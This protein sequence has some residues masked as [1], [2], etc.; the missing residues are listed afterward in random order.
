MDCPS[1]YADFNLIE[2]VLDYL[3]RGFSQLGFPPGTLRKN[4]H[5]E[6][7]ALYPLTLVDAHLNCLTAHCAQVWSCLHH[8][9]DVNQALNKFK[10]YIDGTSI[11]F[12]SDPQF[13]K[14]LVKLK[15]LIRR[16]VPIGICNYNPA[17]LTWST[18]PKSLAH[19]ASQGAHLWVSTGVTIPRCP[20]DLFLFPRGL[21]SVDSRVQWSDETR[22]LLYILP[23]WENLEDYSTRSYWI[24]SQRI[25]LKRDHST[26]S[27]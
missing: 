24:F 15:S 27:E 17:I 7:C 26:F 1:R 2:H 21:L 3:E 14:W 18:F 6:E 16:L 12:A 25:V 22:Q 20:R 13:L 8:V 9:V 4:M 23:T 5:L 19:R 10:D 11:T